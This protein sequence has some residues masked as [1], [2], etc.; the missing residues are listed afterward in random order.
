MTPA[1]QRTVPGEVRI[2]GDLARPV[3]VAL[4]R[5]V[6][7]IPSG[8][9]RR[10]PAARTENGATRAAGGTIVPGPWRPHHP[11]VRVAVCRS[12]S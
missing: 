4:A 1:K 7:E 3:E 10:S 8:S 12:S 2:P 9:S 6:D 11:S 5:S